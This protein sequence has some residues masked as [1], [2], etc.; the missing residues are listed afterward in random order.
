MRLYIRACNYC[1]RKFFL[2]IV[3]SN[4]SIL[5]NS[6][7]YNF[8]VKCPYCG[9]FSYHNVNEVRAERGVLTTPA[10]AVVGGL[11]G[12]IGGP[13]GVLIGGGIGAMIG[14]KKDAEETR[15]VDRFNRS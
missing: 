15:R 8:Q 7:G 13:L 4:R 9:N 6:L 14:G 2:T 12:L 1:N 10:G 3:R 5:A 11:I